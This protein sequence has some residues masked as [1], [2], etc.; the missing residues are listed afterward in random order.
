MSIF[1]RE[2]LKPQVKDTIKRA[3]RQ[4]CLQFSEQYYLLTLFNRLSLLWLFAS[5]PY[6]IS[7]SVGLYMIV[8]KED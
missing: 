2:Y 5:H 6:M 7:H 4:T 3:K 8:E 1:E